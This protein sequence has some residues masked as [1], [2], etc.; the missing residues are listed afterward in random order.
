M[1]VRLACPPGSPDCSPQPEP[2]AGDGCG[3]ELTAWLDRGRLPPR[4]PGE[5]RMPVLPMRC[6]A[7]R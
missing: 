5:R 4:A 7:L 3:A 2:P 6:E 1:H